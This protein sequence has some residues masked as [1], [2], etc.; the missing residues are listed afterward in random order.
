MI[1]A[2]DNPNFLTWKASREV[3]AILA[4]SRRNV[5]YEGIGFGLVIERGDS[6]D[7]RRVILITDSARIHP[8]IIEEMRKGLF[9][10]RLWSAGEDHE[11]TPGEVETGNG[12]IKIRADIDADTLASIAAGPDT[13]WIGLFSR[14]Q[15]ILIQEEV[16]TTNLKATLESLAH[17]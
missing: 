15:S 6:A 5:S 16:H 11:M 8:A 14:L 1:P 17:S 4:Q 9:A 12:L 2:T 7:Q 3:F 10:A 13:F